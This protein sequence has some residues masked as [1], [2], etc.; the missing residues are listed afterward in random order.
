MMRV[1]RPAVHAVE[2][3]LSETCSAMRGT[4]LSSV[5]LCSGRQRETQI[6]EDV[7]T[8]DEHCHKEELSSRAVNGRRTSRVPCRN[9]LACVKTQFTSVVV[10]VVN[11]SRKGLCFRTVEQ[12]SPGT[13][14]SVATYYI[15]G[16]Q[17]IFQKGTI[18]RVRYSR[19][20]ILTEYGVE[21]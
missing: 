3:I 7:F 14:V 19:S 21:F 11:I 16:G 13:T 10:D 9:V 4:R 6:P 5:P 20:G 2:P 15:E 8:N 18:V 12:F 1:Q 17:N